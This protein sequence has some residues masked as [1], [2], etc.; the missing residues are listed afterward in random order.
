M[1]LGILSG[2]SGRKFNISM[3]S[4][5]FAEDLGYESIWTAEAYGS[6]AVTPAA[7]ILAQTQ[8]IKVGTA[9]MQMPARSPAM[10]AMTA[11]SLAELSGGRF[12]C[13]VG[14]SGPQVVEGWHG[15]PYGKPVSRLKEYVQIMKRIFAR[16][17]PLSFEG[18]MYSLPYIGEGA[19]GLGKP[20]KSILHCK[21]DIPIFAAN[22]TPKGVAAAAEVCDGFFPIWMDPEKFSVFQDSINEGFTKAGEKDMTQFEVSP[23]VTVSIGDDLEQCMAPIRSSMALYIGGMGARDK[24]FYNNYAKAMGFEEAAIEIQD[25]FLAGKKDEAAAAVP[26]ELIDACHLVGPADRIKDRLQRWKKAG[27]VGQVAS[28]LLGTQHNEALELIA[29]EIL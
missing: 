12:I 13:G 2:Y 28:M 29:G 18:K 10:A 4:I 19:T 3:D 21:E 17:A 9:I 27:S 25:L 22:I 6:D 7:W 8:K 20:L 5:R 24:N 14:A 16:E 1:K 23:F 15:V 26:A 11:M